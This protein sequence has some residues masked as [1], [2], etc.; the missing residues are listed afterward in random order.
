MTSSDGEAASP[1]PSHPPLPLAPVAAPPLCPRRQRQ[2]APRRGT[3]RRRLL[4][5]GTLGRRAPG[6][7]HLRRPVGTDLRHGPRTHAA[8]PT[9]GR[10]GR[11]GSV[12]QRRLD[13]QCRRAGP[14]LGARRRPQ[15]RPPAHQR[16]DTGGRWGAR[17]PRGG[18]QRRRRAP[19]RPGA[20]RDGVTRRGGAPVERGHGRVRRNF[21]GGGGA[22]GGRAVGRLGGGRHPLCDV[23]ARQ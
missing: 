8:A 3:L 10:R 20:G 13:V 7:R 9:V 15:G 23:G 1:P 18:H 11:G 19:D 4:P 5:A 16:V 14:P 21:W 2:G 17:R 12:L 22:P 6:A